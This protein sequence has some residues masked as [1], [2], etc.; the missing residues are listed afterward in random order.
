MLRSWPE[1][2]F[3]SL[4]AVTRQPLCVRLPLKGGS[5]TTL[6]VSRTAAASNPSARVRRLPS[7]S[8]RTGSMVKCCRSAFRQPSWT[9]RAAAPISESA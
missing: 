9:T 7:G 5:P 3:G 4:T 8:G 6:P 2:T 1:A